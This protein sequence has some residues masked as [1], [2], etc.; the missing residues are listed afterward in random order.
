MKRLS[1][2][3]PY[4]LLTLLFALG[5]LLLRFGAPP[6]QT[7]RTERPAVAQE[8]ALT[9]AERHTSPPPEHRIEL[10]TADVSELTLL[11]GIGRT[12]AQ[13]IVDYRASCGG[14]SDPRELL[15][16]TGIGEKKLEQLLDYVTVEEQYENSGRGR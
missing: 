16:V 12:L 10:N 3:L 13:R 4:A 6:E 5:C 9:G 14:F 7:V 1:R 2:A 11:P 15:N 8:A